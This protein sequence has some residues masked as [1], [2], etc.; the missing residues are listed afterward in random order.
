MGQQSIWAILFSLSVA[1]GPAYA[2][3][4][5]ES[6]TCEYDRGRYEEELESHRDEN[7]CLAR[8][9]TIVWRVGHVFYVTLAD[10]SEKTIN[11]VQEAQAIDPDYHLRLGGYD[12]QN[13]VV[14]LDE[15]GINHP[16]GVAVIDLVTGAIIHVTSRPVFSPDGRSAISMGSRSGFESLDLFAVIDFSIRP[17]TRRVKVMTSG[18][19][20]SNIE[21]EFPTWD[22]NDRIRFKAQRNQSGSVV[23]DEVVADRQDGWQAKWLSPR[24]PAEP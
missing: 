24:Q 7:S 4:Q 1:A 18:L 6:H 22:G 15:L 14:V 8:L 21:L 17:A 10:G 3:P 11:L 16:Y 20:D 2:A 12:S 23:Y 19:D 5:V 13:Q 9:A